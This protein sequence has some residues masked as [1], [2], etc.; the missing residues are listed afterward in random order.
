MPFPLSCI[1]NVEQRIKNKV[2]VNM[3]VGQRTIQNLFTD[4]TNSYRASRGH[5]YGIGAALNVTERVVVAK[6][7]FPLGKVPSRVNQGVKTDTFT[8]HS[9]ESLQDLSG[10]SILVLFFLFHANVA[11]SSPHR[12]INC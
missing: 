9:T 11:N 3:T 12:G 4:I 1:G 10:K 6:G 7:N 8:Y 5:F 2:M